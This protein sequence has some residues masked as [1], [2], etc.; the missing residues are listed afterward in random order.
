MDSCFGRNDVEEAR[1][2]EASGFSIWDCQMDIISWLLLYRNIYCLTANWQESGGSL[3]SNP[4]CHCVEFSV[5]AAEID[6]AIGNR[7]G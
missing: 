1:H 3:V 4:L 7:G 2:D 5:I 6:Y